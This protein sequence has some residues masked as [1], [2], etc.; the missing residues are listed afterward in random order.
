MA[1]YKCWCCK[2]LITNEEDICIKKIGKLRRKFHIS[3]NCYE[4]FCKLQDEKESEK[5]AKEEEFKK[6]SELYEYVKKEILEYEPNMQMSPLVIGELQS[7]KNGGKIGKGAIPNGGYPCEVILAA[8]KLKKQDIK[9]AITKNGITDERK[10]I[11]YITAIIRNSINDV[12]IRHINK[13]KA[14]KEILSRK[15]VV[16]K[17]SRNVEYI[18]KSEINKNNDIFNDMW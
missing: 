1:L 7:L 9:Y 4:T 18:K 11:R 16:V 17:P 2:E 5:K 3:K 8:F 10:K 13:E 15:E 12:Y 14:R 6:W